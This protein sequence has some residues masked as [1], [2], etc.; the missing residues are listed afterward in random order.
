MGTGSVDRTEQLGPTLPDGRSGDEADGMAW[1]DT[2][3]AGLDAR[4]SIVATARGDVQIGREGRGPPVLVSHGGPGGFDQGLAWCRHLAEGGCEVVAPSRPGYLRTPLRSGR[5]PGEQADLFAA[6]LD[7]LGIERVTIFGFS[8]GGPTAVHFAARHPDRTAAL[9][10]DTAVLLPFEPPIGRL[11][12]AT[13]ESGPA[14]W[15]THQLATRMPGLMSSFMISGVSVGSSKEQQRVAAAWITSDPKRLRNV[16]E[17][18]RSIAPRK[19]RRAGWANDLANEAEL[20]PLPFADV[21][22][23][24]LIAYGANDAIVPI[25]H[26]TNAAQQIAGAELLIVEEGHHLLSMSPHY[27]PVAARQLELARPGS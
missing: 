25:E 4:S 15:L 2:V 21:A 17:Q 16:Q 1:A 11:R 7:A 8:S 26:A 12:R 27:G 22:A 14:V 10:L 3:L 23:P 13:F 6:L 24:A 19:D 18:W 5:T 9:L 20:A